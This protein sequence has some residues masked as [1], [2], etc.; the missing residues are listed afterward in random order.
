MITMLK[1]PT[2]WLGLTVALIAG[3]L[4]PLGFAPLEWWPISIFSVAAIWWLLNG[5]T[6]KYSMALG[7]SF[8]LGYFGV[9]VSWVYV[10]INTFG[11]AAPP[12]AV[13]LTIIFIAILSLF[14]VLLG[15]LN[16]RFI[17]R[18]SLITQ[19]IFFATIWLILDI[20]RGSGFVSFPWLYLGYTQTSGPLLGVASLVGVHGVTL[21]LVVISCLVAV[22]LT[23]EIGRA[24]V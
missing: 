17:N 5:Q 4:Y 10:S 24:H 15:W 12:L 8:G 6:R 22:A 23:Y 3:A 14:F 11:N 20:A 19:I 16:A 7:F 21:L 1:S 13:F 9:G 2:G 18:Y